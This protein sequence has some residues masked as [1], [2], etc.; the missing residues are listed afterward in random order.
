MTMRTVSITELKA[1]LSAYLRQVKAGGRIVVTDRGRP[2]AV[3]G[4]VE[5]ASDQDRLARLQAEG[6]ISPGS[7]KVSDTYWDLDLPRDPD[8]ALLQALLAD[9]EEGW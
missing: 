1:R 5:R 4:P 9:R 6:V 8:G 3:L 7:G 2:V